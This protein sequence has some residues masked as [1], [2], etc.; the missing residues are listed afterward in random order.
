MVNYTITL[1]DTEAQAFTYAAV[2]PQE[3]IQ[4]AA[5]YRSTVAIDD[6]VK[7]CVEQC[8]ATQTPIPSTKDEMVTL[9][10]EKGWVVPLAN[11]IP[12]PQEQA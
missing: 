4:N 11:N 8:L 9:A 2:S 1:T 10:F 7:I 12:I 3:W 6:I 5:Q